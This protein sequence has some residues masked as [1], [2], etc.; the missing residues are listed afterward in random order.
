MLQEAKRL[1]HSS[2]T[3]RWNFVDDLLMPFDIADLHFVVSRKYDN[4]KGWS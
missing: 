2:R 3:D 4:E 1:L